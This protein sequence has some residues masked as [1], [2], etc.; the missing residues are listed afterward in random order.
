MTQHTTYG[1]KRAACAP[2][3][4]YPSKDGW[5]G[6]SFASFAKRS[7]QLSKLYLLNWQLPL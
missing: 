5:L 7:W 4:R 6:L 3:P 2:M 1:T